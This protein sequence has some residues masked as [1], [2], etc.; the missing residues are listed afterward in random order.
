MPIIQVDHVTKEYKLGQFTSLKQTALNSLNRLTGRP[1]E[2]RKPFKAVDV[3]D[4]A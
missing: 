1:V 3:L 4:E 2:E